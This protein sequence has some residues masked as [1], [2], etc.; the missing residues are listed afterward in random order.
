MRIFRHSAAVLMG[1]KRRGLTFPKVFDSGIS[2]SIFNLAF[3][4]VYACRQAGLTSSMILTSMVNQNTF[5]D[6]RWQMAWCHDY[7][8]SMNYWFSPFCR[9]QR[10]QQ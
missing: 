5:S 2:A 8:F 9:K 1:I 7:L 10:E 6:L 4:I 3:K